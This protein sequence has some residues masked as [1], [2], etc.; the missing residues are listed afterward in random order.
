[1]GGNIGI[2][3]TVAAFPV[4][5]VLLLVTRMSL[6]VPTHFM[7]MEQHFRNSIDLDAE[8][9]E[10][11]YDQEMLSDIINDN[12]RGELQKAES[13]LVDD[14][15][16]DHGQKI[17]RLDPCEICLC[18]DG[19]IFCWWKQ[20][21]SLAKTVDDADPQISSPQQPPKSDQTSTE[22]ISEASTVMSTA[23]EAK[24]KSSFD[25]VATEDNRNGATRLVLADSLSDGGT[26]VISS[27]LPI[28]TPA[29]KAPDSDHSSSE[30]VTHH[31]SVHTTD[32]LDGIPKNILSFPQTPPIMMY[33]PVSMGPITSTTS[34][35]GK[36][37][38]GGRKVTKVGSAATGVR[39]GKAGTLGHKKLK[40]H[41]KNL[42]KGKY[43][44]EF[45]YEFDRKPTVSIASD[46]L[47]K[48][49]EIDSSREGDKF[50]DQSVEVTERKNNVP[51]GKNGPEQQQQQFG[52]YGYGMIHESESEHR[53]AT[54]P[55]R[56]H[57]RDVPQHY[58][59]TS[60]GHVEMFDDS[61]AMAGPELGTENHGDGLEK[62]PYR[63]VLSFDGR[64][65]SRVTQDQATNGD[66][67]SDVTDSD[68]GDDEEERLDDVGAVA[69]AIM[70]TTNVTQGKY[71]LGEGLHSTQVPPSPSSVI[72]ILNSTT[73]ET[74]DYVDGTNHSELIYPEVPSM[75]SSG[76]SS[77]ISSSTITPPTTRQDQSEQ[78]CVVMGVTYPVGA[79][80]KQETGNCLQCV[81][82]AGPENDPA[83]RVT[84]TPLNCP[85]LILPDI[86][87]GA[88]F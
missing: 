27:T 16:Y 19:E 62:Q 24:S 81:C 50:R 46:A 31:G 12:D 25:A 73:L 21:D 22:L 88:G 7:E 56:S 57:D 85:P 18:I 72:D 79:V 13:C 2:M 87:D 5:I 40:E 32:V 86:L 14:Y 36:Y 39:K 65:S 48:I 3:S 1:M 68:E 20:C 63:D 26:T 54:V 37:A 33:R 34:R 71:S 42:L 35:E 64:V 52:G 69:P 49:S 78:H 80:L 77:S 29:S 58:I 76:G 74:T 53:Q 60:S 28:S 59:I 45:S 82:V 9:T 83:P 15:K 43:E 11:R 17:Q 47:P 6:C 8:Q 10:A 67:D 75:S 44:G 30:T 70:L 4:V 55:M 61:G 66:E 41:K 23:Y 51:D 84:C 38:D